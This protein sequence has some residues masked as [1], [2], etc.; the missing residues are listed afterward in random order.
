M[1][2]PI[3]EQI[4]N[5]VV[6][7]S[8]YALIALG[9]TLIYGVLGVVNFAHGELYMLGAYVLFF[10]LTALHL[11]YFLAIALVLLVGLI[12]GPLIELITVRPVEKQ[13]KLST[14]ITTLGLSIVLS[15]SAILAFTAS[16]RFVQTALAETVFSFLGVSIPAQRVVVML[17]S[18]LLI[19]GAWAY[20]KYSLWGKAMRAVAENPSV[21]PLMG[22]NPRTVTSQTFALAT[23]L[24]T[25]SGA[26]LA[27]LF[28]INPFIGTIAGLKAFAVVILG[29][30]GN[31][32]GAI[33]AGLLLGITE[34]VATGLTTTDYRDAIA[35]TVLVIALLVRPFGLI[36]EE[37]AENV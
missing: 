26:L 21:A 28:V 3:L 16:P 9:L 33:L 12:V 17:V 6:I 1:V 11:N 4:L 36:K 25:A 2:S 23:A 18:L 13:R 31:I 7:G 14:L 34:S 8:G 24:A 29:G 32:Q 5:G 15:N 22:I 35:F 10:L 37:L 27:P 20:V 19:A 30:F